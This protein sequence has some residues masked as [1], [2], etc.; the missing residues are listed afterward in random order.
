MRFTYPAR[1]A[2]ALLLA[3]F[4][5]A[6]PIHAQGS[7][8]PGCKRERVKPERPASGREAAEDSIRDNV[9]SAV[10]FDARESTRAAGV[11]EPAGL[12]LISLD[13]D[14][15]TPRVH[16]AGSNVPAG[17]AQEVAL[18]AVPLM[19]TWPDRG[20]VH[21]TLRLDS[22]PLPERVVGTVRVLCEPRLSNMD[23]VRR[24]L[25]QQV[26]A[27]RA[28][29]ERARNRNT[30]RIKMLVAR[31]GSVAFAE[32]DRSSRDPLI[33]GIALRLADQMRFTPGSIDGVP[34]DVW[35]VLPITAAV[36]RN[37]AP[38]SGDW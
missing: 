25:H 30:T 21:L 36:P 10:M 38:S 35:A 4:V 8:G 31:D 20:E 23:E 16:L 29:V 17:V 18:R 28:Q 2:T 27:N 24:M 14:R 9:Q 33:D 15:R 37:S 22:I 5:W 19:A 7:D 12:F 26:E 3:G 32:I 1:F 11:A 34:V 6:A 13:A